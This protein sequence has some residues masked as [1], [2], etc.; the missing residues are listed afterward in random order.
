VKTVEAAVIGVGWV[1]GTR[2]ET[3]SRTALVDKLHLCDIKPDRL[4]RAAHWARLAL[5]LDVAKLCFEGPESELQLTANTQPAVLTVSVAGARLLAERGLVPAIVGGHSLGEYSALVVAGAMPFADAVG[6]VRRRGE[7]M[8]EAVPVGT[9]A[10]A[11]I[12]GVELPVVEEICRDA[13][14]GDVLDVANIN[15]PGQIVVAGHRAAIERAVALAAERGE[16]LFDHHLVEVLL[17]LPLEIGV[18]VHLMILSGGEAWSNLV[19]YDSITRILGFQSRFRWILPR[20]ARAGEL[21]EVPARGLLP[22][23]LGI[24]PDAFRDRR[25]DEYLDEGVVWFLDQLLP[26]AHRPEL[27]NASRFLTQLADCRRIGAV[28]LIMLGAG[29]DIVVAAGLLL[30]CCADAYHVSLQDRLRA[31]QG[32]FVDAEGFQQSRQLIASVRSLANHGI[33]LGR[34]YA[35]VPR[36]SCEI[37]A[38]HIAK[39]AHLLPVLEPVTE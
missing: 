21:R 29:V 4:D 17:H 26:V 11:A 35:K 18:G 36:D 19:Q 37:D 30:A 8:Q 20:T 28:F 33:E 1:G 14:Q 24:A 32:R 3:L 31:R 6:V 23:T 7:F 13:A 16:L 22:E 25:I 5:G 15:S 38:V 27:T 39:L 2:V 34:A 12:L 10:M 9:G